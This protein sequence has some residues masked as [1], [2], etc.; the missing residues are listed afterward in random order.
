M[1]ASGGGKEAKEETKKEAVGVRRG[2]ERR[3]DGATRP[4]LPLPVFLF[5][6]S[7]KGG[8]VREEEEGRGRGSAGVVPPD[9]DQSPLF[10]VSFHLL[11][12]AGAD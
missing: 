5:S 4:E 2:E 1:A 7:G 8:G 6:P 9:L 3:G 10:L 12:L 11:S